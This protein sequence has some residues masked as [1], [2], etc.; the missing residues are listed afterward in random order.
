MKYIITESQLK[1]LLEQKRIANFEIPN[2]SRIT[3]FTEFLTQNQ[4][5]FIRAM[6]DE[7][8]DA[9]SKFNTMYSLFKMLE[10]GNIKVGELIN[11]KPVEQYITRQGGLRDDFI[12]FSKQLDEVKPTQ[13][14]IKS[15]KGYKTMSELS[16][17][18]K[19][20]LFRRLGIS[21]DMVDMSWRY[22]GSGPEKYSGWKFHVYG[23]DLYDSAELFEKLLP[24]SKKWGFHAKVGVNTKIQPN[25]VQWGKQGASVF[26]PPEVIKNGKTID[27][28]N[29]INTALGDYKK[30]G[31]ISG[32]KEINNRIH[33]RYEFN[34]PIDYGVGVT[35]SHYKALRKDNKGGPYKPDNVPDLFDIN[36]KQI[37]QNKNIKFNSGEVIQSNRINDTMI[38]W[39]KVKNAKNLRDYNLLISKALKENNFSAISSG[40]FEQYGISDF[41]DFLQN[42]IK[43][44][45]IKY[46]IQT[47][48]WSVVV[49]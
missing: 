21:D 25:D 35:D 44:D 36:Q 46:N 32:D 17:D 48:D 9:T 26:I 24:L 15:N 29:D 41:R 20:S 7:V 10:S 38:D 16:N 34:S 2:F 19:S 27:L 8:S 49:K 33:Y 5:K 13:N 12:K 30:S 22:F 31:K 37:P 42:N 43:S 1:R 28:L 14:T 45:Q 18:E 6:S 11:G 3:D 39:S 47:G 40:G 23:E 4:T